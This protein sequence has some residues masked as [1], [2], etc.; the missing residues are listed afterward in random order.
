MSTIS[1]TIRLIALIWSSVC[2]Q[3]TLRRAMV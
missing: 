2:V 3:R 1:G